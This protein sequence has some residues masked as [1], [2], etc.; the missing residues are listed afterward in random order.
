MCILSCRF[1]EMPPDELA[2]V[3]EEIMDARQLSAPDLKGGA[4]LQNLRPK[5]GDQTPGEPSTSRRSSSLEAQDTATV[6]N[7]HGPEVF[8][9]GKDVGKSEEKGGSRTAEEA[10]GG[11]GNAYSRLDEKR[12]RNEERFLEQDGLRVPSFGAMKTLGGKER[13]DAEGL[14][15]NLASRWG[16]GEASEPG[17]LDR[18]G[19]KSGHE[20]AVVFDSKVNEGVRF[21][22][23][24]RGG[25]K[26]GGNAKP[27][28]GDSSRAD[29]SGVWR[30]SE[31]KSMEPAM[32]GRGDDV[33]ADISDAGAEGMPQLGAEEAGDDD[34]TLERLKAAGIDVESL[35]L[36]E[37]GGSGL[38]NEK[39]EATSLFGG[40]RMG[41]EGL[42]GALMGAVETMKGL[43]VDPEALFAPARGALPT[44]GF[45]ALEDAVQDADGFGVLQESGR[46]WAVENWARQGVPVQVAV[47]AAFSAILFLVVTAVK[48]AFDALRGRRVDVGNGRDAA[49][50]D[51]IP[52]GARGSGLERP[53]ASRAAMS[54]SVIR[55]AGG[56]P[57]GQVVV[58]GA[59]SGGAG[60]G[61]T[62]AWWQWGG[63]ASG[64]DVSRSRSD[65]S[66]STGVSAAGVK[67]PLWVRRGDV[68]APEQLNGSETDPLLSGGVGS[69]G[70]SVLTRSREGLKVMSG[71]GREGATSLYSEQSALR[72]KVPEIL[73]VE[74]TSQMASRMMS[75][76]GSSEGERLRPNN[77][78][79]S[80]QSSVLSADGRSGEKLSKHA[81]SSPLAGGVTKEAGE[82]GSITQLLSRRRPKRLS[83]GLDFLRIDGEERE[84]LEARRQSGAEASRSLRGGAVLIGGPGVKGL[85]SAGEEE[86][87]ARLRTLKGVNG[88]QFGV[89]ARGSQRGVASLTGGEEKERKGIRGEPKTEG[90]EELSR[91]AGAEMGGWNER[92][93]DSG[94]KREGL[95]ERGMNGGGE[96]SDWKG[97]NE[98]EPT[99]RRPKVGSRSSEIRGEDR[100]EESHRGG[101]GGEFSAEVWLEEGVSPQ[102]AVAGDEKVVGIAGGLIGIRRRRESGWEGEAGKGFTWKEDFG[103]IAASKTREPP[104][105]ERSAGEGIPIDPTP[106]R[107]AEDTR[108]KVHSELLGGN[109][110]GE[111]AGFEA[112]LLAARRGNGFPG[113]RMKRPVKGPSR[114]LQFLAE[115][116]A[117]EAERSE[118]RKSPTLLVRSE[119][120]RY[121]RHV[122]LGTELQGGVERRKS[123]GLDKQVGVMQ[124][125]AA[126]VDHPRRLGMLETGKAAEQA[127]FALKDLGEGV[128]S[129]QYARLSLGDLLD[130]NGGVDRERAEGLSDG[131]RVLTYSG[132][133][134]ARTGMPSVEN[135]TLSARSV[136]R[137]PS[138]G[139][140]QSGATALKER[141]V[142]VPSVPS[143]S[144]CTRQFAADELGGKGMGEEEPVKEKATRSELQVSETGIDLGEVVEEEGFR[145]RSG[146]ADCSNDEGGQ[147]PDRRGHPFSDE[148]DGEKAGR[149]S[150]R[151]PGGDGIIASR[152]GSIVNGHAD[153]T[154][155][156]E[157]EHLKN[158]WQEAFRQ[159]RRDFWAEG[160]TR[161]FSEVPSKR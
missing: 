83:R 57:R 61:G 60:G 117:T 152:P 82:L 97:D 118:P 115:V 157:G 119:G 104:R 158:D 101:S 87:E 120:R 100:K 95:R 53:P 3:L 27:E 18:G 141:P 139:V 22:A 80:R 1:H 79:A 62:P 85:G 151:P 12:A 142:V 140:A 28:S 69:G 31:D 20:G 68:A 108:E 16:P 96:T 147:L 35:L 149:G 26:P 38:R 47:G 78:V 9:L 40:V 126:A 48:G 137:G 73:P 75:R 146:L 6:S 39:M 110:A 145:E 55:R 135:G 84:R 30:P 24:L 72:R 44:A 161:E 70:D 123:G 112:R 14:P 114:G 64:A 121:V 93:M 89:E 94:G 92:S 7:A 131:P 13:G 25:D 76:N 36:G 153:G 91:D 74:E 43:R 102:K 103:K 71:G 59:P 2:A 46:R 33:T 127:G 106:P 49:L 138:E 45:K 122:V 32:L 37:G 21:G 132:E 41:F 86:R 130:S 17:G 109:D 4:E 99:E 19:S 51:T 124:K 5:T 66:G 155:N 77:P 143:R 105:D 10:M 98:G 160:N 136:A 113:H 8:S 65:V 52:T 128:N 150:D 154:R 129:R 50:G 88:H 156:E 81:A 159:S 42:A 23:G 34:V 67:A 58:N 134:F 29:G 63:A 107:N 90:K 54:S 56:E 144:S 125:A 148:V 116:R 133:G 15:T 111:H 11:P